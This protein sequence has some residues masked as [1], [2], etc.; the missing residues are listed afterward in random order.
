MDPFGARRV[1]PPPRSV[2]QVLQLGFGP[3]E[4]K[5]KAVPMS[6]ASGSMWLYQPPSSHTVREEEGNRLGLVSIPGEHCKM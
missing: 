1:F 2:F 3:C 4:Q 5:N 6:P